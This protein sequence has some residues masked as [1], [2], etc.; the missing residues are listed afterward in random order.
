MRISAE[1]VGIGFGV[2]VELSVVV[3]VDDGNSVIKPTTLMT[4]NVPSSVAVL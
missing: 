4:A 2:C 3:V 1:H